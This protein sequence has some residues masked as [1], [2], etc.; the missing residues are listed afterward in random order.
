M[1]SDGKVTI[2]W[3]EIK[4]GLPRIIM[5][6]FLGIVISTPLELKIF[7]DAID[8]RIEQ[9]KDKLLQ[10]KISGSVQ[11]RD[12]IAQKRDE[13]MNGVALFD[14]QITT[15]STETNSLLSGIQT[16]QGKIAPIRAKVQGLSNQIRVLDSRIAVAKRITL[17]MLRFCKKKCFAFTM[18]EFANTVESSKFGSKK[19]SGEAAA[20]DGRLKDLMARKQDETTKESERLQHD[21][22]SIN[23]IINE[24]NVRH[25]DWDERT[26]KE[27]GSFRDK[28]DVE[29]KGFQAK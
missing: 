21:V 8:I 29:Y 10:D 22:D 17:D 7:E 18:F 12:S 24:A 27:R 2:S 4:S 19:K 16:L 20:S 25:K 3:Q 9:D 5:A 6:I 15:S 11:L 14:S 26:I 13:I 23:N 1:Y 28:L